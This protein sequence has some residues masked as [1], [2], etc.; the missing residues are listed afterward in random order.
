MTVYNQHVFTS[1]SV[2]PTG[3][4]HGREHAKGEEPTAIDCPACE[5]YLVADGWVSS[6]DQV[7]KTVAQIADEERREREG[8]SAVRQA[9]EAMARVAAE[10]VGVDRAPRAPRAPRRATKARARA[11]SS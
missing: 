10:A 6:P 3:H 7:P 4:Q 11:R 1:V 8:N 5:P 9:A 2:G